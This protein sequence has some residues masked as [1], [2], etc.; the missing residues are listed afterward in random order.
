MDQRHD[1][2]SCFQHRRYRPSFSRRDGSHPGH[3]GARLAQLD[4]DAYARENVRI[5]NEIV[6][7]LEGVR[8]RSSAA[9]ALDSYERLAFRNEALFRA[10]GPVTQ[11]QRDEAMRKHGAALDAV[12]KRQNAQLERLAQAP[13]GGLAFLNERRRIQKAAKR[14]D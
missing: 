5:L 6:T 13:Y 11:A 12:L 7:V 10:T 3:G 8:D 14:R 4:V 2:I 9:K 1:R